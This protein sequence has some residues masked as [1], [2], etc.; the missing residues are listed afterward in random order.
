V[1]RRRVDRRVNEAEL[2][3]SDGFIAK[4]SFSASPLKSLDN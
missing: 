1:K 2:H 3:I 4:R